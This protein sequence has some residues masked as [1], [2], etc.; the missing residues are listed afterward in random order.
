MREYRKKN[1][2]NDNYW[3][4]KAKEKEHNLRLQVQRQLKDDISMFELAGYYFSYDK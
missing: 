1:K 3:E 2:T 4:K